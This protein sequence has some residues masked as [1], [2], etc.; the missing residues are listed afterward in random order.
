LEGGVRKDEESAHADRDPEKTNSRG[1]P[2]R[3]STKSET[4]SNKSVAGSGKSPHTRERWKI[5]KK[6]YYTSRRKGVVMTTRK[7]YC[8]ILGVEKGS[9]RV[10]KEGSRKDRM[11]SWMIWKKNRKKSGRPGTSGV[12]SG[13]GEVLKKKKTD[14]AKP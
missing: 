3:T 4:V 1:V 10:E 12:A 8:R 5:R 11:G 9:V 7:R 2:P 13:G 6:D 14:G